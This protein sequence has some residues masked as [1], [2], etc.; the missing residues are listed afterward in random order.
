MK[1]QYTNAK[2]LWVITGAIISWFAVL[3]Q[4]Y[5]IIHNRVTPISETIIRFF[6]FFTVLT[7][8]LVALCFTFLLN[9]SSKAG[10]FFSSS[11]ALSAVTAYITVVG[12]VYNLILRQLWQPAGL[13]KLADELLHSI[14]PVYFILYWLL[15]VVKTN[16]QWKNVLL[17]LLYPFVYLMFIMFRGTVSGFYPYPFINVTDLGYNKIFL[18]S[19]ILLIAFLFISLLLVAI[20]KMITRTR[21]N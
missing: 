2:K 15:F 17:W 12:I 7:N 20:A 9:P 14:I 11:K 19:F 3:L 1:Q 13:Q 4:L 18:N 5:L 8:I 6:S 21:G 16:L 10:K